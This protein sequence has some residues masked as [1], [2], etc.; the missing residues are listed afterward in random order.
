MAKFRIIERTYEN[1]STEYIIQTKAFR[2]LFMWVEVDAYVGSVIHTATHKTLEQAEF[3]ISYY[4]KSRRI[5][6]VI[7]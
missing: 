1:K 5:D 3:H 7:S 2:T 4:D 6:K